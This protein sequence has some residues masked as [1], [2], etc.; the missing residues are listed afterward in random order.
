MRGLYFVVL[1]MFLPSSTYAIDDFDPASQEWFGLQQFAQLAESMGYDLVLD[2]M[3]DW[4]QTPTTDPLIII[5]PRRDPDGESLADWVADGGRVLYMDDFGDSDSFL[6]RLDITRVEPSAGTLPHNTFVDDMPGF[7]LFK[8]HGRHPLLE[9]VETIVANHP[10]V[11]SNEGGPVVAY[12]AGGALVYDMNLGQGKAILMADSS[13]F[14]NQMMGVAD[15]AV[16]A[17]NALDYLCKQQRPCRIRLFH[18]DFGT[19]GSYRRNGFDSANLDQGIG[20]VNSFIEKMLAEIPGQEL[21][22]YLAIL[23]SIGFAAYLMTIFPLRRMRAYSAYVHDFYRSIP[24][25]QSEFDWNLA[26]FGS[27]N[28]SLNYALPLSILKEVFEEI[29]LDAL[30]LWPSEPGARPNIASMAQMYDQ[31]YLKQLPDAERRKIHGEVLQLLVELTAIPPRNRVFL[32]GD[33]HFGSADLLRLHRRVLET[34]NRMGLD[35]EF[36]RRTQGSI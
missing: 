29:F 13:L 19:V 22:Y 1:L 2:D 35:D 16:L 18:G 34:L 27:P 4:T 9:G 32:D 24:E 28:R 21:L 25:P 10:A 20:S 8:P 23:L 26:R 14:L 31:K 30:G 5:Y 15:N 7:P 36:T 17:A 12:N 33:M 3:L 11:I 6:S